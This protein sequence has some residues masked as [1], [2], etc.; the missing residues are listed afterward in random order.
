MQN[1]RAVQ[2]RAPCRK[3]YEYLHHTCH[4]HP[5]RREF[6]ELGFKYDNLL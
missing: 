3:P 2:R 6:L 5:P 4:T 1:F